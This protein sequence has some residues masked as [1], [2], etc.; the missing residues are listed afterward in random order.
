M[1]PLTSFDDLPTEMICELFKHL[2][3]HDL[4]S[5]KLVCKRFNSIV[6]SHS[7]M[8]RMVV[9]R[10]FE[11]L[12][13]WYHSNR[14]T[15]EYLETCHQ[16]LFL[17]HYN[18][19]ILSALKYLRLDTE[20]PEFDIDRLNLFSGLLQLDLNYSLSGR[21]TLKLESLEILK[22]WQI[23]NA[24]LSIKCP[25]LRVLFC[26]EEDW[27]EDQNQL[28]IK[29]PETIKELDS[30]NY[31]RVIEPMKN[32]EVL[33]CHKLNAIGERTLQMLPKLKR[34]SYEDHLALLIF[35]SGSFEALKMV[36]EEFI[37][38]RRAMKRSDLELYLDGVRVD[39][40]LDE[41]DFDPVRLANV[42]S[43]SEHFHLKNYGRLQ[44]G[45]L[46]FVQQLNYGLL[47]DAVGSGRLPDDFFDKFTN[48]DLLLVHRPVDESQFLWF[49]RNL[50]SK[51]CRM[52]LKNTGLS[53]AFYSAL[54]SICSPF[55][56][57]IEEE[58]EMSLDCSFLNEMRCLI[59][60]KTNQELPTE[61]VKSFIKSL[62]RE[63]GN[64]KFKFNGQPLHIRFE[65][66][67]GQF[68]LS[69]DGKLELQNVGL[70]EIVEWLG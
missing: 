20:I 38:R 52:E 56:I 39:D 12:Q 33:K 43:T 18:R 4:I 67:T 54:P 31:A 8:V 9:D 21:L 48:L 69:K 7:R 66:S 55:S 35:E 24:Q 57:Q 2:S 34:L 49:L 26:W 60:V 68:E 27:E 19:P 50:K 22:I 63:F 25:K 40:K 30:L 14:R 3:L 58:H 45:A 46:D 64:L 6:S 61:L 17:R 47:M 23:Q 1:S 59:N 51:L 13:G 44:G 70:D 62:K 42:G 28:S 32:L 41:I 36:L 11:N 10:V 65:K 15:D 16:N 37:R 29:H 5:C 53:Q